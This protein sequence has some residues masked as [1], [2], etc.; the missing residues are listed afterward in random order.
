M[1]VEGG[2]V[3]FRGVHTRQGN[4]A[5]DHPRLNSCNDSNTSGTHVISMHIMVYIEK[6]GCAAFSRWHRWLKEQ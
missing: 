5:Y 1:P 4:V 6:K 3:V 2:R